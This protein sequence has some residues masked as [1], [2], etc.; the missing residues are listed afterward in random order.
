MDKAKRLEEHL[1]N[2]LFVSGALFRRGVWFVCT[3]R[4]GDSDLDSSVG[5]E[6][7]F[8][9]PPSDDNGDN[10]DDSMVA[11]RSAAS[12]S[13]LT[14]RRCDLLDQGAQR[15]PLVRENVV[16]WTTQEQTW[17]TEEELR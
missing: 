16:D 1:A 14:V 8:V 4:G 11:A 7:F 17:P 3:G 15:E 5:R 13:S 6:T 2:I 10:D 12:V 9:S